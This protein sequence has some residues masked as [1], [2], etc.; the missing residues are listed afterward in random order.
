MPIPA[1]LGTAQRIGPAAVDGVSSG[2][3]VV[4]I[5]VGGEAVASVGTEV[6]GADPS[7][8]VDSTIGVSGGAEVGDVLD[9]AEVTVADPDTPPLLAPPLDPVELRP[10][11]GGE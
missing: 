3:V 6:V 2:T 7:G 10:P 11:V 4:V 9:V 1:T 8:T 5:V